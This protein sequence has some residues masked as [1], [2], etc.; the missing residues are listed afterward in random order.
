MVDGCTRENKASA[1]VVGQ[2]R[3]TW[4]PSYWC[5]S[6]RNSR[7]CQATEHCLNQIWSQQTIQTKNGDNV[8]QYCINIINKLNTIITDSK[9][10][11]DFLD[12]RLPLRNIFL[13][14]QI[15]AK[16]WLDDMCNTLPGKDAID[17]V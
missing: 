16:T 13:L 10:K 6:L 14:I 9:I 1:V 17:Q 4:G 2:S 12:K 8:C 5:S 15:D 7:D 3:C 11:V